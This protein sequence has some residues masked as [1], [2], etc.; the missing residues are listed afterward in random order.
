MSPIY[1]I[2]I[3]LEIEVIAGLCDMNKIIETSFGTKILPSRIAASSVS[4][5]KQKGAFYCFSVRL[6]SD[7]I[8][9]YSFSDRNRALT[10]RKVFIGHLEQKVILDAQR[11]V[12]R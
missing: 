9:E 11:V 1:A 7:D 3:S 8:R 5:V 6:N 4:Q 2:G 12:R 10:M